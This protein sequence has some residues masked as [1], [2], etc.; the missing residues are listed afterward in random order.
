MFSGTTSN[1][2]RT[3]DE[4]LARPNARVSNPA[5]LP[6]LGPRRCP[7]ARKTAMPKRHESG[8]MSYIASYILAWGWSN[9]EPYDGV[10][11]VYLELIMTSVSHVCAH[12]FG[13]AAR[14]WDR[15]LLRVMI[16]RGLC[17]F[18]ED[19][20]GRLFPEGKTDKGQGKGKGTLIVRVWIIRSETSLYHKVRAY[21]PYTKD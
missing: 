9:K 14:S 1:Q 18:C 16:V 13:T 11:P 10:T 6:W 19:G 7:S 15:E 3:I 20:M 4:R 17:K 21:S 5:G 2:A 8:G 12:P